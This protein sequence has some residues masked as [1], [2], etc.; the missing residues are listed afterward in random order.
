MI[1]RVVTHPH[2]QIALRQVMLQ[3]VVTILPA[4]NHVDVRHPSAATPHLHLAAVSL[5]APVQ[6]FRVDIQHPPIL[7]MVA[8]HPD[9]AVLLLAAHLLVHVHVTTLPIVTAPK[10]TTHSAAM[11]LKMI[12]AISRDLSHAIRA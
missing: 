3:L 12:A 10:K 5:D 6:S 8:R 4:L 11:S 1:A 9:V 2:R 7:R